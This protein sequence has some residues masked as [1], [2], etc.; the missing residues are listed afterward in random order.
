MP[1]SISTDFG[2]ISGSLSGIKRMDD[3]PDLSYKILTGDFIIST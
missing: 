3:F 1:K 2:G